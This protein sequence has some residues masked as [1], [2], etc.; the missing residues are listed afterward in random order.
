MLGGV[1]LLGG[2][3]PSKGGVVVGLGGRDPSRVADGVGRELVQLDDKIPL[4]VDP[5]GILS[6]APREKAEHTK[7][8]TSAG[9]CS[10]KR[11]SATASRGWGKGEKRVGCRALREARW[12]KE[13]RKIL[14]VSSSTSP[15]AQRRH[16]RCARSRRTRAGPRPAG[17]GGETLSCDEAARAAADAERAGCTRRGAAAAPP[18]GGRATGV[19]RPVSIRRK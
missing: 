5:R 7:S 11:R 19:H 9:G 8:A 1:V 4:V 13:Q 3:D 18:R 6:Y 10:R 16:T 17:G 12:G 14:C 2:Q 15:L